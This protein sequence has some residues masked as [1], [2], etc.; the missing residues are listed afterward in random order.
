MIIF[1]DRLGTSVGKTQKKGRFLTALWEVIRGT[2][3]VT[4]CRGAVAVD[5]TGAPLTEPPN[6]IAACSGGVYTFPVLKPDV[7][8]ELVEE[9]LNAKVR[10]R[11]FCAIYI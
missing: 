6:A 11:H 5:E 1:Q 4:R 8:R 7:S 9:I 10:K 3:H 2:D